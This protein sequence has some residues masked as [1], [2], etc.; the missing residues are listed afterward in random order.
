M[1]IRVVIVDDN[2]MV[3]AGLRSL[4]DVGGIDVVAEA[5]DG[6]QALAVV[7]AHRPDVT[8]LDYRM[9]VADGLEVL[10]ELADRT[11]VLLMTSD[12][13]ADVVSAALARGASGFLTHDELRP[14]EL[15]RAVTAVAAGEAWLTP[16][17]AAVAVQQLRGRAERESA[18]RIRFGLTRRERELMDLL[19]RGMTNAQIADE[20][21]LT[22]KTV[23]NHL[24]HVFAKLGVGHRAEAIARWQGTE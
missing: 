14:D 10:S 12:R 16:M 9:P 3:R 7:A 8:L 19:L 5:G 1:T 4:L 6:R 13:S 11:R 17:A 22:E 15:L 2:P 20:L 18:A 21:V 23:K 24:N